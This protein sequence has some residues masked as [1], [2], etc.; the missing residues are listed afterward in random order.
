MGWGMRSS[1]L[2]LR[3]SWKIKLHGEIKA[4]HSKPGK[5]KGGVCSPLVVSRWPVLPFKGS[6]SHG[7]GGFGKVRAEACRSAV[8]LTGRLTG[9]WQRGREAKVMHF[10]EHVL[11]L[12]AR[13]WRICT[14]Y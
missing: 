1:K 2:M 7:K 8:G 4:N 13:M 11:T 9:Q 6:I 5:P 10:K 3:G 14:I 12:V